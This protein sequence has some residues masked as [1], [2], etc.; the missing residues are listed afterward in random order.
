MYMALAPVS[1][2]P[3]SFCM[4]C[5]A[6]N[7]TIRWGS[8]E[9]GSAL[10]PDG[11]T[12]SKG[13]VHGGR[14][15]PLHYFFKRSLMTDVMATCGSRYHHPGQSLCYLS[16]HRASR[17][18]NGTVTLTAYD[19]FGNGSGKVLLHQRMTLP[20]GPGAI[21][22]FGLPG[23]RP[24]PDGN[25][26]AVMSTVRDEAGAVVSEH[27]VQL[28]TPEFIRVP[29]ATL[30]L[31]IA[32]AANADGTIDISVTS[33]RVA[34]WVT[35]TT[36]AQGRFTDNAFFLPAGTRALKFVPFSSSTA[37]D[38]LAVLRAS[39]RVEDYSMNRALAPLPPPPRPNASSYVEVPA[40]TNCSASGIAPVSAADCGAACRALGFKWTG[41]RAR[42]NISGCFVMA[43]GQFAGNC[44]FNSNK[45][46][47]CSPPCSVLGSEVRSL[48]ARN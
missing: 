31:A 33:D 6:P 19:H 3:L 44:N 7:P 42:A 45:S 48:C 26:T 24:L 37:T 14:W 28:V 30:S 47:T 16:N 9:Y 40:D 1:F 11:K 38:D 15:K 18:F 32:D 43:S 22:W 29:N 10:S 34:L 13:Q 35:L 23:G 25:S 12:G 2:R 41:T 27:I 21:A 17:P 46:A 8:L 5:T 39:L 20:H 4:C 36:L